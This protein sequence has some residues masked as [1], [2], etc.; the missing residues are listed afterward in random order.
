MNALVTEKAK[1]N[2]SLCGM[3]L[4]IDRFR[5]TQANEPK[6]EDGAKLLATL[7]AG[8]ALGGKVVGMFHW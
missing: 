7:L 3:N 6:R 8:H 2:F 1:H 5:L 4:T